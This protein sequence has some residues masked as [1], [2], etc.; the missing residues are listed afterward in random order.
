MRAGA[1]IIAVFPQRLNRP[2]QKIFR[3]HGRSRRMQ[4]WV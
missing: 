4:P 2:L 1:P 3:E